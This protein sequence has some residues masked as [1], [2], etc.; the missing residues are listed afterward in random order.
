MKIALYILLLK[1]I[2]IAGSEKV[3]INQNPRVALFVT[4]PISDNYVLI[5]HPSS[6]IIRKI[7]DGNTVIKKIS[8][9]AFLF[10]GTFYPITYSYEGILRYIISPSSTESPSKFRIYYNPGSSNE[11]CMTENSC[12]KE[13]LFQEIQFSKLTS[14]SP[15]DE[16]KFLAS[17]VNVTNNRC[18]FAIFDLSSNSHILLSENLQEYCSNPD[19]SLNVFYINNQYIFIK[20]NSGIVESGTFNT[21][22]NTLNKSSNQIKL[23]NGCENLSQLQVIKM[24]DDKYMNCFINSN[25]DNVCCATGSFENEI[26][27]LGTFKSDIT[28][29]QSKYFSMNMLDNNL[30]MIGCPLADDEKYNTILYSDD[31]RV[32]YNTSVFGNSTD[33][34]IKDFT[35]L[36]NKNLYTVEYHPGCKSIHEQN[37]DKSK[38]PSSDGNC[39]DKTI[40][41]KVQ[42]THKYVKIEINE[43]DPENVSF[44]YGDCNNYLN[45]FKSNA[46]SSVSINIKYPFNDIYINQSYGID[47]SNSYY[48]DKK[49][50]SNIFG[51]DYKVYCYLDMTSCDYSC[52]SCNPFSIS[53]TEMNCKTCIQSSPESNAY[54]FKQYSDSDLG[55]CCENNNPYCSEYDRNCT[56]KGC[57]EGFNL[58]ESEC[59]INITDKIILMNET[60]TKKIDLFNYTELYGLK[61]KITRNTNFLGTISIK[62]SLTNAYDIIAENI[63]ETNDIE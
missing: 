62:N 45:Y 32:R 48:S 21:S 40:N 49:Y 63:I 29:S 57:I 3:D 46:Y 52:L 50:S 27:K 15:I 25:N 55:N 14:L 26:Y 4:R 7:G 56:C 53:K 9:P 58:I 61:I 42:D 54:I 43:R 47:C 23:G 51:D 36:P 17:Y 38:I 24:V 30:L 11:N 10:Q 37:L 34:L 2:F 18:E 12:I 39:E 1:F 35:I 60:Q 20:S 31:R 8:N 6:T 19:Q 13:N 59:K 5:F 22:T 41:I 44:N 28:C 33:H 16:N